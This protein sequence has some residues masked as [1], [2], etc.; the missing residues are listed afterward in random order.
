L[1]RDYKTET[2]NW[3]GSVYST[4]KST[5]NGRD[6]ATLVR[7]YSGN[8]SSTTFQDTTVTFSTNGSITGLAYV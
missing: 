8:D 2:L 4:V 1:G 5:F 3:T 7:Q 6:Q